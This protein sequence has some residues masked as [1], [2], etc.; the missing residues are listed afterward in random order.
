M[1]QLEDAT[2]RLDAAIARLEQAAAEGG[3]AKTASP[4]SAEAEQDN[5]L[6]RDRADAVAGRLDKAIDRLKTLLES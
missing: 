2:Q 5:A 6:L 3:Q 4:A 1:S